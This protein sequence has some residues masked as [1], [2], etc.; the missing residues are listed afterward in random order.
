MEGVLDGK[1]DG[2]ADG[3]MDKLGATLGP[4]EGANEIV[5]DRLGWKLSLGDS[6]GAADRVGSWDV[7]GA[8]EGMIVSITRYSIILFFILK[9]VPPGPS[10]M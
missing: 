6:L 8:V 10:S 2:M 9:L 3:L 4:D 7:L 1:A 5:G